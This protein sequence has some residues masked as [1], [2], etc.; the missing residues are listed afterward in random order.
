[1]KNFKEYIPALPGEAEE[2]ADCPSEADIGHP[3]PY[4]C[5][6]DKGHDGEHRAHGF[7]G[8]YATWEDGDE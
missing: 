6:R 4:I 2:K 7:R 5:T 3:F 1:V 8:L